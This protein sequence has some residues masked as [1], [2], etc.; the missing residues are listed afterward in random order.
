MTGFE[1]LEAEDGEVGLRLAKESQPDLVLCDIDMP[2]KDGFEVL[3]SFRS[4]GA[5]S[6]VPFIFITGKGDRDFMRRGMD[7]GADDFITKPFTSNDLISSVTGRLR[8]HEQRQQETERRLE[9]LRAS[10]STSVPHELNTPLTGILGYTEILC[11]QWAKLKD[12]EV[13]EITDRISTSA[14][15][16]QKTL[17]KFWVYARILFIASDR[18]SLEEFRGEYLEKAHEFLSSLARIK[19]SAYGRLKDLHL[20]VQEL[21]VRMSGRHFAQMVEE[22]LDNAFKFSDRGSPVEVRL[23]RKSDARRILIRIQDHGRGM[24][25]DQLK[26]LGGFMQMD[27]DI[28][29]QQGLGLGVSIAQKLAAIYDGELRIESNEGAGTTVTLDL[30]A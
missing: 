14:D 11:S 21:G 22:M 3:A 29:E 26:A 15:R 19:A 8:R 28:Q 1:V 6:L 7:L 27:R 20:L 9:E 25:Q 16:L 18:K 30:P 17:N 5:T 4:E 13:R 10:I 23:E 24:N 2:K 12:E